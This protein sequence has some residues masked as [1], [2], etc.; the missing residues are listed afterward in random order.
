MQCETIRELMIDLI[1]GEEIE[2]LQEVQAH[3]ETCV[4]CMREYRRLEQDLARLKARRAELIP[5]DKNWVDFLPGIRRKISLRETKRM[6]WMPV[7]RMAPIFL[8][9]AVILFLFK[10]KYPV[11]E[12]MVP[13][14]GSLM[15]DVSTFGI[16]E[17]EMQELLQLELSENDLY[18]NL[19]DEDD[20]KVLQT[21]DNWLTKGQDVI[22]RLMQLTEEEQQQVFERLGQ[23]L[24]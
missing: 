23:G 7:R 2:N 13:I 24:L 16:S 10:V 4:S 14:D 19:V 18:D 22:D 1:E 20:T 3:L 12:S 6:S 21:M 9:T 11:T 5:D 15:G 8:L 17:N